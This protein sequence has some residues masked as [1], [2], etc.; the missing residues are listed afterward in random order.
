MDVTSLTALAR[1]Y[2]AH[3]GLALSTVSTYAADDGKYFRRLEGGA[4]CTI[5][6]A[7]RIVRWFSDH[8]P[9]DLEWPRDIPRPPKSKREAA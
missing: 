2:A 3:R 7:N 6:K 4:G 1:L 9:P 5:G 8:W